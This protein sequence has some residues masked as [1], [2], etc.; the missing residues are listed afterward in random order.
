LIFQEGL[1]IICVDFNDSLPYSLL[2]FFPGYLSPSVVIF[3]IE[4]YTLSEESNFAFGKCYLSFV[5]AVLNQCENEEC[6]E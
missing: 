4:M 1:A 2:S 5:V 3:F 6:R